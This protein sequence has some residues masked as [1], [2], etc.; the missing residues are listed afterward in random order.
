MKAAFLIH[1]FASD[2]DDFARL[3]PLLRTR[4]DFVY[5]PDLPFHSKNEL[6]MPMDSK[7]I[8]EFVTGG[9]DF[10]K[11]KYKTVDVIGFSMG[12][13]LA[14]YLS[15]TRDVNKLILLAPANK[16]I[17]GSFIFST[18]KYYFDNTPLRK[19][20]RVAGDEKCLSCYSDVKKDTLG[21]VKMFTRQL[22][23]RYT[24][25]NLA[26]FSKVIRA[27][28]KD[29]KQITPPTL[30]IWGRLDQL[31]PY[32]SLTYLDKMCS[33]YKRQKVYADLSHYMLYSH[34][35]CHIIDDIFV[36]LEETEPPMLTQTK[37]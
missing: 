6:K 12:G 32:A 16:Y 19:A 3:V 7:K 30:I 36:F 24:P 17:S 28:N 8:I 14:V 23:P 22:L 33:G 9:F 5:C 21:A 2:R 26:E 34:G 18:A 37:S 35:F 4:Y 10:L 31:V 11:E 13:A 27:C 25:K 15:K 20:K 29:L 1:G